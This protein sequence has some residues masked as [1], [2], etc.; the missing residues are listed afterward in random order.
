MRRTKS[1]IIHFLSRVGVSIVGFFGTLYLTRV[2]GAEI[3]GQY[4]VALSLIY[5]M[6]VPSNALSSA[7]TKRVSESEHGGSYIGAGFLTT[8]A[9]ILILSGLLFLFDE[10]VSM[11]VE[12]DITLLIIFAVAARVAYPAMSAGLSGQLKV[13]YTGILN[14]VEHFLRVALQVGLVVLGWGL[15]GAM[16][17]YGIAAIVTIALG[18]VFYDI[19]PKIPRRH[20]F[21]GLFSF[22]RYSWLGSIK[23][24]VAGAAI[25]VIFLKF[26]VGTSIIAIYQISWNLAAL[27]VMVSGSI[28]QVLFPEVSLLASND[29]YEK[30]RDLLE[31]ALIFSGLFVFPGLLGGALIG[32]RVLRIYGPE[33]S[34]G[35]SILLLLI[36]ARMISAFGS[37]LVGTI[38]GVDRPDLAFR[39]NLTLVVS[40]IILDVLLIPFIGWYGAAIATAA[41]S[42]TTVVLGYHYLTDLIGTIEI[43]IG[44]FGKQVIASITMGLFVYFF[45]DFVPEYNHYAT[46]L[47]VFI[48]AGLYITIILA[49]S[50]TVREKTFGLTPLNF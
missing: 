5:W 27:L 44:E 34:K 3:Y 46:V 17:G 39:V 2:L 37:Q 30:V 20:H 48:G 22:V 45:R 9:F 25:D 31:E 6:T 38:N 7:I 11:Y 40:N 15:A 42:L 28:Q 47:L 1:S 10:Q 23:A 32:E 49:I 26:F 12:R 33:F 21:A 13:G 43:P 36:I 4:V 16:F 14:V 24:K 8:I 19:R 18:L 29:E 35:A 50:K 41:A